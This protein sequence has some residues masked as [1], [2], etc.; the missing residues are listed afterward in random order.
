MLIG[1]D[2][3]FLWVGHPKSGELGVVEDLL[4]DRAFVLDPQE[5]AMIC[6]LVDVKPTVPHNVSNAL[7][8]A[9]IARSLGVAHEAIQK[10][11]RVLHLTSSHRSG[12][13]KRW[14]YMD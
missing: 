1:K 6:E 5:A 7:A 8:A 11:S 13:R 3:R 4:V 9:G 12:V 2:E 10:L 14:G